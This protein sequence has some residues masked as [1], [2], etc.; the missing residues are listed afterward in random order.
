[1]SAPTA[2]DITRI[3][4]GYNRAEADS[5]Y[6]DSLVFAAENITGTRYKYILSGQNIYS[7]VDE[8]GD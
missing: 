1:M 2:Q 4:A 3:I 7:E 5:D 8:N 6:V